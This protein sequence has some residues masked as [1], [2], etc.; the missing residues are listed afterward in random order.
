MQVR[1]GPNYAEDQQVR[2]LAYSQ[3]NSEYNEQGKDIAIR[4]DSVRKAILG[5]LPTWRKNFAQDEEGAVLFKK[6]MDGHSVYWEIGQAA[7]YLD[8]LGKRLPVVEH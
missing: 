6:A 4:G 1:G 3:L 8:N 5:R 2:K 7:E